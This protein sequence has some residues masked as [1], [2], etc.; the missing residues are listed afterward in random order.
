MSSTYD[1]VLK[2]FADAIGEVGTVAIR[3]SGTRWNLGGELA[4]DTRV[5]EAPEGIVRFTPDEMTVQVRAG[6][7]VAELHSELARHG[8][9]TALAERG[10]TVGGALMAGENDLRML[11]RGRIR[12]AALQIRYV[13]ADGR[14]ISAGGPTVKNVTGFDLPRLLVGSLGTIGLMGEAILRTNPLPAV[15][16][17][18]QSVDVNPSEVRDVLHTASLILFNGERT[19]VEL[20]GNALDLE[21]ELKVLSRIGSWEEVNELPELPVHRWSLRPSESVAFDFASNG[22]AEAVLGVGMVFASTPQ[23]PSDI[24]PVLQK[25][26]D[27]IKQQFDPTGRLNPGRTAVRRT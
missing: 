27:A 22:P 6:T 13:S 17:C 11:G 12:E 15:R 5:L 23:P 26:N 21:A 1:A 9:R 4:P 19:M 25:L 8:Q 18:F 16:R 14:V 20:E 7:S 3:G 2:D 24:D 10:G